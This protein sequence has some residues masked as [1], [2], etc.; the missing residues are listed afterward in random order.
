MINK[1]SWLHYG[2]L[3]IVGLILALIP[4][5]TGGS[6]YY[7]RLAT[8]MLVYMTYAI[9]FNIIFGH[10]KQLFLCMGALAGCSAYISVV[11]IG[12][13]GLPPGV[14]MPLGVLF[15]GLLGAFF[16]YASVRRGLGVIFVGV[17][18]IAFSLVFHNLIL[19]LRVFTYGEDGI[20][21][22]GLGFGVLEHALASYYILLAILLLVLLLYHFLI[23]SRIGL[24]FR[25]LSDNEKVAE[26]AGIDVT[27]Y[28]VFAAFIGS[29]LFGIAGAFYAQYNG[30]ISPAVFSFPSVDV[31]V[32]VMVLL[33]G[34]GTLV[35]PIIGAGVFTVVNE[36][37]RPLGY[38]NLLVYG[39]S[40]V[41]LFLLFREG[42]VVTL[43]KVVRLRIP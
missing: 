5:A 20:V 40:L 15:A 37:M 8:L 19:G 22:R 42:L 13:L 4:L 25:A 3:L 32:F 34:M 35:G 24:A 17:I 26:L 30:F 10:T 14:T 16:S 11:L 21:T 33:G 39:V 31:V 41:V 43:R 36:L 38:L 7:F 6:P 23:S 27:R 29:A 18:T 28:K 2:A 1:R 9:A 12:E